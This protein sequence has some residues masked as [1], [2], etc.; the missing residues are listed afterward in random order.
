MVDGVRVPFDG[1]SW[2]FAEGRIAPGRNA[3]AYAA[4]AEAIGTAYPAVAGGTAAR[5]RGLRPNPSGPSRNATAA[6][7]ETPWSILFGFGFEDIGGAEQRAQVMGRA[8][9]FLLAPR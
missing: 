6:A 1:L 5:Y 4:T 3:A 8:L 7:V 2:S 9:R